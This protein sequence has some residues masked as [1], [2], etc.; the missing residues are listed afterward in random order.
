MSTA[1]ESPLPVMTD[2]QQLTAQ[3][4]RIADALEKLVSVARC[5][6]EPVKC[7]DGEIRGILRT[8]DTTPHT[9]ETRNGG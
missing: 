5:I 1:I 8:F 2:V 4:T 7:A 3:A 9:V 6:V